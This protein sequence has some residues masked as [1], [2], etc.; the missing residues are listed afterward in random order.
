MATGLVEVRVR[1]L[2]A[3]AVLDLGGDITSQAA[4]DL[5]QAY[6]RAIEIDPAAILLNF[7]SVSYINST[8]IALLV[9]ILARARR[10]HRRVLAIGLSDHYVEIFR[11]T[12]LSDFMDLFDDED[13]AIR[14]MSPAAT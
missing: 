4:S 8:G 10:E 3:L 9:G 6:E 11:I 7:T 12:R 14:A 2:S 5:E 1:H 13:T